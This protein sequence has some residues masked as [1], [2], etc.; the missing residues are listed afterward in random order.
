[1]A[2]SLF[3]LKLSETGRSITYIGRIL[4]GDCTIPI[5]ISRVEDKNGFAVMKK[6]AYKQEIAGRFKLHAII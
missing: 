5:E 3:F 1:M 2:Q 6:G 4:H